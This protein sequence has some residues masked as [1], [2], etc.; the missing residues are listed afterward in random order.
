MRK[1]I[2]RKKGEDKDEDGKWSIIKSKKVKKKVL[3][4]SY[5]LL[6]AKILVLFSITTEYELSICFCL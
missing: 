1:N 6:S 2:I 5:C 4:W 3:G